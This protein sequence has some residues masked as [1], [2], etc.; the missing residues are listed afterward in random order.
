ME[1]STWVWGAASSSARPWAPVSTPATTPA[2]ARQ[3]ASRSLAVSPATAIERH[4]VD[5]EPHQRVQGQ[6]GVGAAPQPVARAR[7]SRSTRSAQPRAS[8]MSCWVSAANPV[9]RQIFTP[10]DAHGR[11][12]VLGAGQGR[13]AAGPHRLGD[14]RLEAAGGA[15][16]QVLVAEQSPED[17]DLRLAH[18]GLHVLEAA[19]HG[20]V[21]AGDADALEREQ[22]RRLDDA[23]VADGGAGHVEHGQADLGRRARR[24]DR[25]SVTGAIRSRRW[26][27]RRWPATGS[28]PA[29]PAR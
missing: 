5:A 2:P 1:S 13:H 28:C 26:S 23:V 14:G 7:A 12:G 24:V 16:G 25:R 3:P 8:T 4:V 19:G 17:L 6:V 18:G 11:E 20:R 10:A 22:E 29:R 21:V 9:V 27:A 15:L